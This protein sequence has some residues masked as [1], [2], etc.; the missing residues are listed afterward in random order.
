MGKR[1]SEDDIRNYLPD[2]A[3]IVKRAD[4]AYSEKLYREAMDNPEL[5]QALAERK[6]WLEQHGGD[7][8]DETTANAGA[9]PS[10]GA[11]S[12]DAAPTA[13]PTHISA[14]SPWTTSAGAEVIDR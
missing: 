7:E 6:R 2:L 3:T 9:R 14:P 5:D 10:A 4:P 12:A 8:G 13:A 11:V 1:D